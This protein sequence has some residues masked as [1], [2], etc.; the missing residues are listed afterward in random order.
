MVRHHFDNKERTEAKVGVE[1]Q[2]MVSEMLAFTWKRWCLCISRM[3]ATLHHPK[4]AKVTSHSCFNSLQR[5]K[6]KLYCIFII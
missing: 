5:D 2:C 4:C 1:S 3:V 6:E